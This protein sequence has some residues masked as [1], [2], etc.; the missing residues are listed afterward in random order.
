MKNEESFKLL[1]ESDQ[2]DKINEINDRYENSSRINP[3]KTSHVEDFNIWYFII[4]TIG[5]MYG[6]MGW[7][8]SQAYNSSAKSAHEAKMGQVL[9]NF[10]GMPQATF[11]LFVPIVIY[12]FMNHPDYIDISNSVKASLNKLDS[13]TLKTQLR[14]PLVL[15]EVL[16]VGLLGAFA[17]LMLAA[18][19]STHDT[20]LHSWGSILIQDVIM[21]F[22]KKPFDKETHLKVLRIS[23][24]GV[25]I[26][27]FFFQSVISAKSKN[28]VIFCHYCCHFCRRFRSCNYRRIILEKR[29]NRCGLDCNDYWCSHCSRWD[30]H[31]TNI[32]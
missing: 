32:I 2:T 15:A 20:Y 29:N 24:F 17:A 11:M 3:F 14:A 22:R 13:E 12:V 19:V 25:A 18:F 30:Y 6:W 23:I 1:T 21:P 27:I 28:S 26:F 5:F 31:E 8:G 4:G 9:G 7:Q 16:P 10:R